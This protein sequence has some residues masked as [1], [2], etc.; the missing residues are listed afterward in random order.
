MMM[1]SPRHHDPHVAEAIANSI[2]HGLGLVASL[3]ALPLLILVAAA[4]GDVLQI[5]GAAIYGSSLVILYAASTLYHSFATSPSRRLL[6]L[7]DHSAIY[8]LIAGSYTPFAL[9]PLRGAFGYS[10]LVA[11]WSMALAG[12]ALKALKGFGRPWLTV[13]P[14][15]VMGWIAVIG[16]RPL[17]IHVGPAGLAWL[18]AGGVFYTGGVVFY[19]NDH[20]LRYGHAMWHLCVLLGSA[21]HFLAVL[22]HSGASRSGS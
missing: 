2:T 8:V 10:L 6:R 18:L 9:G 16:I 12:I 19:A 14:Y 1:T 3:V 13:A 20:R 7:L 22:W 11:V 15:I 17:W 4:R 21:C 5:I